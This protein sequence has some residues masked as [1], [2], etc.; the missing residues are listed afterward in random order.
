MRPVNKNARVLLDNELRIRGLCEA[1]DL[2]K[3]LEISLPTLHRI[4]R[5]REQDIVRIGTT[6][7]AR[8]G[9]RRTLRG[10]SESIPVYAIDQNGRGKQLTSMDLVTSQGA[11][12]DVRAM[13]WPVSNDT[14][15]WWDGLP[16]PLMDMR[17]QGFLGRS[18]AR[19][20]AQDFN[21]S[22]NPEEWSDDD[23]V[24]ILTVRGSDN[25]GNL[26]IG[27]IAY[28]DFLQSVAQ[29]E[30][31]ISERDLKSKYVELAKSATQFG[32]GGSSAGG[33]FPK[34]TAKRDLKEASNPYVIVKFSGA[35][36]SISVR[37]WSDLLIC[38]HLAL[39]VLRK[40]CILNAPLSRIIQYEGRTFLEVERFDRIGEFG[41]LATTSLAS[42]DNAFVGMRN[43]SWV[44]ASRRLVKEKVIPPST[45]NN[46]SILWWYGKLIANTDMHFGNLTFLIEPEIK[47]SPA[48]DMLP[49]SYAPLAGG[50]VPERHFQ[51]TLPMPNEQEEWNK[52]FAMALEFWSTASSDSRITDSF[53]SICKAN[54]MA[55]AELDNR[56][57]ILT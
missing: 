48:Y 12:L 14:Y 21:V 33:E 28:K 6:K 36:D 11:V 54:Y 52:A 46:I 24:Y 16:Y 30:Y 7:N 22:D 51:V 31:A 15:T 17:P 23:I 42:L 57:K 37:R 29:P 34:F 25:Q 18:L 32:G 40:S 4:I 3:A 44:E 26:I 45:I 19:Q 1:A 50:E 47:L 56:L 20:I 55:L 5:E 8:Y 2:S 43:G 35:D 41:R 49:M 27:E 13:R 53:K 10:R 38:E 9:L 39:E